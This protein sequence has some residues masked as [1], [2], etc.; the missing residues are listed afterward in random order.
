MIP[1]PLVPSWG[2]YSAFTRMQTKKQLDLK[3]V[4]FVTHW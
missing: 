1:E 2:L 3:Q 4:E